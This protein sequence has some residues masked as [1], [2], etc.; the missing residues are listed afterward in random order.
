MLCTVSL[1][2]HTD[3]GIRHAIGHTVMSEE[4]YLL[5][6][7]LALVR[8]VTVGTKPTVTS[9]SSKKRHSRCKIGGEDNNT[10]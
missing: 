9:P 7:D 8:R 5:D 2:A 1:F 4:I 6:D 3:T 10:K